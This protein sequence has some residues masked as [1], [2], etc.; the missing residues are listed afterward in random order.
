MGSIAQSIAAARTKRADILARLDALLKSIEGP[1][2]REFD[3]DEA[4]E[5]A[6]LKAQAERVNIELETLYADER[7]AGARARPILGDGLTVA[8]GAPGESRLAQ[9]IRAGNFLAQVGQ[10]FVG[11]QQIAMQ[12]RDLLGS[13]TG[14]VVVPAQMVPTIGSV[15]PTFGSLI[16][17]VPHLT[18]G[19]ASAE[20]N[21]LEFVTPPGQAAVA[22][23]GTAKAQ[24]PVKSVAVNI[25]MKVYAHWER[26]S[27]Q[28][29]ADSAQTV[30]ALSQ[31]LLNGA[32]N[33]A[34]AAAYSFLTTTGNYTAFSPAAGTN[35]LDNAA[36]VASQL[37][38]AGSTRPAVF[39][40]P[41]DWLAA[42]TERAT[43]AGTYVGSPPALQGV[44]VVQSASVPAGK[45]LGTDANGTGAIWFDRALA[46]VEVG[47]AGDDFI[48][49]LRTLLAELRGAPAV[50]NPALVLWGNANGA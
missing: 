27:T 9:A 37:A 50:R 15:A 4:K 24:S 35:C 3:V 42:G 31:M 18:C 22:P 26:V 10:G 19:S 16:A 45:I 43:T 41:T 40:S 1:Q 30:D 13:G 20:M 17:N 6:N 21:R 36:D 14:G 48:K 44:R 28:L 34:D 23:E 29:L 5:F 49:N 32:L 7:A 39:V 46:T 38:V 47:M 11:R 33:V 8:L 12:L 25:P 2:A